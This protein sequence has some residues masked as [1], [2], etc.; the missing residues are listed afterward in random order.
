M[1]SLSGMLW[2]ELRKALRSRMPLF[3]VVGSL[4]MPLGIA[5]LIFVATH[6]EVSRKLGLVGAKANLMAYAST[7]W[8]AYLGLTAM[9]IAAGGFFLFCLIVCWVFGREFVDGTL[10]DMLA[11]PVPRASILLAKFIVAAVWFAVLA[12]VIFLAGLLTGAL[13]GLPGGSPSVILRGA[14]LVAGTTCLVIAVVLPFALF[15]SVG[16]GYLL[17]IGLAILALMTANLLAVM[18]WAEYFP[19]AVPGLFAQGKEALPPIS[20]AIV[21][22]TGLAGMIATYHWWKYADQ[23]R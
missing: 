4:F 7:S 12:G 14:A 16:R 18:G 17:P 10:K 2:I 1:K 5:F 8:P 20:Y 19:W 6:P 22:L 21:L 13:I 9:M 3:T 23:S 11:V 15:A